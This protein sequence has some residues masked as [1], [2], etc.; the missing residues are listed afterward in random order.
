M[1]PKGFGVTSPASNVLATVPS[2]TIQA[3]T[4]ANT[5]RTVEREAL[6]ELSSAPQ[7]LADAPQSPEPA[8]ERPARTS[9]IEE[10]SRPFAR[11]RSASGGPMKVAILSDFVRVPYANGAI[12]QTRALY[13]LLRQCGHQVTIIGPR[14]P[15]ATPAELAPGTIEFPSVPLRTYPGVH[16][17]LPL[18]ASI[19]DPARW[20]FDLVFAQTTSLLV[21]FGIWLRKVKR[22]PL[23]T[24]HTT[25]LAAAYDVLLP[26]WL[27]KGALHRI[28]DRG[29]T[30]P[31]ERLSSGEYNDSDGLIV[32][33]EG[34]R[35]YWR[36]RGVTVPIHV[37]PRT[38]SPDVFDQASGQD[39]YPALLASAGLDP[40]SPR[41]LCA[42]RHTREKCQD[43]LIRIFAEQVLPELPRAVLFMVGI[44][45]DTDYYRKVAADLGVAERVVFTGEVSF[46][47][48]PN[49]YRHADVFAH[50]S[51]S[52]TFGNVLSEAL[53][54]G[55]AAVAMADGM[56]ASSQIR[57]GVNGQLIDPHQPSDRAADRAFGEA[58]IALVGNPLGRRRLG[59]NAARMARERS[60]PD[61]IERRLY[62]AFESAIEASELGGARRQV[63]HGHGRRVPVRAPSP[64]CPRRPHRAASVDR[65]VTARGLQG[66]HPSGQFDF[67]SNSGCREFAPASRGRDDPGGEGFLAVRA[68][69]RSRRR[70]RVRRERPR[71]APQCPFGPRMERPRAQNDRER[72]GSRRLCRGPAGTA[73]LLGRH[74]SALLRLL[75]ARGRGLAPRRYFHSPDDGGH[76]DGARR[77][78]PR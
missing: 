17:P 41:L 29:L 43:R 26:Q 64:E 67:R 62:D 70:R 54:S 39:P 72:C 74:G 73:L 47:Q 16:I 38:V 34:L 35:D 44:G 30:R 14:D 48:M 61:V 37:I 65:R 5:T 11:L 58:V 4:M 3:N 71:A 68:C 60:A 66:P 77:S 33:S 18:S 56:G 19:F 22:I 49:F 10:L 31:L 46:G 59:R 24:V 25:H 55:M 63:G 52:E 32:L 50:T 75:G 27:S 36:A 20:D 76:R 23:L 13:R 7:R 69:R 57:N 51:L 6:D 9:S 21:E 28:V 12:F 15:D 1:P 40:T 8:E 42:G 2:K 45:P 78:P 53:W